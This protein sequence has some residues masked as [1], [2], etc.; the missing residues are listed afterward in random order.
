MRR[1]EASICSTSIWGSRHARSRIHTGSAQP[2]YLPTSRIMTTTRPFVSRQRTARADGTPSAVC[3]CQQI[4]PIDGSICS[5]VGTICARPTVSI[6]IATLGRWAE[7]AAT[8]AHLAAIRQRIPWEVIVVSDGG[9]PVPT[10]PP[11]DRVSGLAQLHGGVAR[12]R[13]LGAE[14]ARGAVLAFIDD[15]VH[16]TESWADALSRFVRSGQVAATGPVYARDQTVV[17]RARSMRYEHRYRGLACSDTVTFLAGGNSLVRADAFLAAGG[18]PATG[19]GADNELAAQVGEP[20]RFCWG[21]GITHQ[22]DRGFTAAV[23]SAW[24][25]GW[26]DA[27][28]TRSVGSLVVDRSQIAPSAVNLLLHGARAAGW[29]ASRVRWRAS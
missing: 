27:R 24:T 8:L 14:H 18:F 21:L 29:T 22:N 6:V 23:V 1:N 11:F 16:P 26:A 12:A 28:R 17:S 15:D 13:N 7:L 25:S 2:E 4:S 5:S 3:T 10:V 9:G 19:A 20:P